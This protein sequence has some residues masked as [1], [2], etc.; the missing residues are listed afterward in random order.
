V[1]CEGAFPNGWC[2]RRGSWHFHRRLWQRYQLRLE[3]GDFTR[4]ASDIRE[5]RAVLLRKGP[6]GKPGSLYAVKLRSGRWIKVVVGKKHMPI[7]ALPWT[8]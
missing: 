5:G 1:T 3:Y 7:S 2:L 6:H 8:R 4:I